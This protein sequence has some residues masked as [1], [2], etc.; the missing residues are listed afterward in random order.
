MAKDLAT[1]RSTVAV[2]KQV[3]GI[4]GSKT[5]RVDRSDK[6]RLVGWIDGV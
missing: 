1:S 4:E 3:L 5:K 2:R 6:G